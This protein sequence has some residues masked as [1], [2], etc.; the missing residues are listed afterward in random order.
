MNPV[1]LAEVRVKNQNQC[2]N[3][4]LYVV[5]RGGVTLFG[6]DWLQHTTL[7]W[8]EIKALVACKVHDSLKTVLNKHSSVFKD[9]WG[10]LK[11]IKAKL[12]VKPDAK[13]KFVKAIQVPYALKPKVE[14]E[15]DKLVKDGILEKCDFCEWATPIVPVSKKDG[16]VRLCGDF[17]V[18]F[19]G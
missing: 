19:R 9:D 15:L 18:T 8:A 1:G 5:K 13:P 7:D 6:R 11:G 10:T 2:K 12:T 16:S 17:K 4:K 14:V 3:F